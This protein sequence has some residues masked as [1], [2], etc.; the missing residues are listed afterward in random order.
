MHICQCQFP[1]HPT[2]SFPLGVHVLVLQDTYT[3]A[4]GHFARV[5]PNHLHFPT[6][7]QGGQAP[8]KVQEL[9]KETA[10]FGLL[11]GEL[12]CDTFIRRRSDGLEFKR[13]V[14]SYTWRRGGSSSRR[15]G[16]QDPLPRHVMAQ[17]V[18]SFSSFSRN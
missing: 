12:H 17:V 16:P 4:F 14:S 10:Y 7:K 9:E 8:C 1:C 2:L 11:E 6:Q 5:A 15:A 13:N 18:S 3:L